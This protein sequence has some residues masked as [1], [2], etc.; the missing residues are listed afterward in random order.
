MR[1]VVGIVR[2]A[3]HHAPFI[4]RLPGSDDDSHGQR[5]LVFAGSSTWRAMTSTGHARF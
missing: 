4:V 5:G 2:P 1:I 3:A